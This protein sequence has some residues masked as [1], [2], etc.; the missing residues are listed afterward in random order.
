MKRLF[1]Q[2]LVFIIMTCTNFVNAQ[3]KTPYQKKV[4][5]LSVQLLRDMGLPQAYINDVIKNGQESI[6]LSLNEVKERVSVFAKTSA[7]KDR[8]LLFMGQLEDA[9]KIKN[10]VDFEREEE[11]KS[12]K[13]EKEEQ[14]KRDILYQ[15]SDYVNLKK[16]IKNSFEKWYNK[17]EFEKTEE[18]H[19]RIQ[20]KALAFDSICYITINRRI[21][22]IYDSYEYSPKIE[23]S[24]Y[25]ADQEIFPLKIIFNQQFVCIS[26]PIEIVNAERFKKETRV[27]LSNEPSDWGIKENYLFPL[28]ISFE[29]IDNK[30]PIEIKISENKNLMNLSFTSSELELSNTVQEELKFD[31]FKY[32]EKDKLKEDERKLKETQE[33]IK[34]HDEN[35]KQGEEY[36]ANDNYKKALEYYQIAEKINKTEQTSAKVVTLR[37]KVK[38]IEN[39]RESLNRFFKR[40]SFDFDYER[41]KSESTRLSSILKSEKDKQIRNN[42]NIVVDFISNKTQSH[43]VFFNENTFSQTGEDLIWTSNEDKIYENYTEYIK[44]VKIWKKLN[45]MVN[46]YHPNHGEFMALLKNEKNPEAIIEKIDQANER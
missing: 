33:K 15:N 4:E 40:K 21:N 44:I 18:Y 38:D 8:I 10:A 46:S 16:Q 45:D 42:Y 23:F 28:K 5:T 6:V 31:F 24:S 36:I 43:E 37:L 22:S 41:M 35:V 1:V 13:K 20:N 30:K 29:N 12:K 11:D 7:G 32:L 27:V 34:K 9:K 17:G 39:K 19:K 3:G 14:K 25:D 26:I 2:L